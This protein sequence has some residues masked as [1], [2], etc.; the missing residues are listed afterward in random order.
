MNNIRYEISVIIEHIITSQVPHNHR[1]NCCR[2]KKKKCNDNFDLNHVEK[3]VS[4]SDQH[5]SF[6]V[7]PVVLWVNE[8]RASLKKVEYIVGLDLYQSL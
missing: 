1:Q 3:R 5:E 8:M 2:R 6:V 4:F 7:V